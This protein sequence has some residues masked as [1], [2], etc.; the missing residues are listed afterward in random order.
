MMHRD[1]EVY[2]D[3]M[4]MKSR[5]R[6]DHLAAL[7][8]FF[9]RIKQ[10][11][12]RLNPKNYT[13]G[14]TFGKLIGYMVSERGIEAYPDNIRVILDMPAPRIKREIKGFLGRPLLLY[15]SVSNVALGCM[16]AQLDDSGKERAIYYLS[17]RMLDYKMRYVMIECYYLA[18]PALI[19]HLMRWL[20]L[21]TEF[22]IHYITQKSIR[23][24][25]IANY[26]ASLLV[27]DGRAIDDDFPY[28]DV[29]TVTSLLGW[30]MHYDGAANH[31][32][33]GIGVLL[34]S[35]YG[36]HIPRSVRLAFS[37]RHPTT[38]NIVE[39][40]AC[41]LGLETTLELKIRQIE[42]FGDSNL[43]LRQIQCKWKTRDVKLS[44][45]IHT[46]SYCLID[47]PTYA[48]VRP[49]LIES[50]SASAYCCLIDEIKLDDDLPWYH[51]IYQF[52]RLGAYPE[53]ATTKDKRALRQ[54]AAQF[55][56]F[57]ETLYRRSAGRMLLLC[58][59]CTF[60][61]RVMRKVHA[62]V[63]GLHMGG[64]MLARKI[65]ETNFCQFV[66]KCLECQ[67]HGD[68]IHVPPSELYA[69]T[70]PWPFSVWGINI[71]GKISLK[72]SSG[73]KLILVAIDY[74]T[75]WVEAA[76]ISLLSDRHKT[77][78]ELLKH[79]KMNSKLG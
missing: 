42:V 23:G 67:I 71:I 8:R 60:T 74:F 30:Q 14:V 73:H 47:I 15:L 78:F 39:Y 3:D 54:L 19:G 36:D 45:T 77:L 46:W 53:A 25:I 4:I 69:L 62:G 10:F 51:D 37:D 20:V 63:C 17:K 43:V 32:G 76:N 28:E 22:D 72:S 65:M 34:I 7:E 61:D 6:V 26:L 9:E 24:C 70:L 75:K 33:Y 79:N 2:V 21:L 18:L 16:L 29:V 55:V 68:L 31:F 41:I 40:E 11:K 49:L 64:H 13:F 44:L 5:D 27:S 66:H 58:L 57:W 12:L 35:P 48:I 52:L 50:R 1:V 56:I 59:S 38:N